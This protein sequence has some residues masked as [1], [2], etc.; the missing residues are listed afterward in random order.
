MGQSPDTCLSMVH[1]ESLYGILGIE[2]H[3]FKAVLLKLLHTSASPGELVR[4]DCFISSSYV[5]WE[6]IFL[7][8]CRWLLLQRL[9]RTTGLG[10]PCRWA[11]KGSCLFN[12]LGVGTVK[13]HQRGSEF[14]VGEPNLSTQEFS[15]LEWNF[16][17]LNF[18]F[19]SWFLCTQ[20]N[21][22]GQRCVLAIRIGL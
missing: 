20:L 22:N 21:V 17:L 12:N 3:Q 16:A 5:A 2:N 18:F 10:D 11:S 19:L 1:R 4:P 13:S 8:C 14:Q 6:F 15:W 9:L 7:T